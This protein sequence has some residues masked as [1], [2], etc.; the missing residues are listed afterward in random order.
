MTDL[1]RKYARLAVRGGVNLQPGQ[2]LMIYAD[3][4]SYA[5]A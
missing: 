4:E 1:L 2:I 5:F 3:I